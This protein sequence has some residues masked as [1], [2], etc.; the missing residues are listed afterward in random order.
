MRFCRSRSCGCPQSI[1]AERRHPRGWLSVW[2]SILERPFAAPGRV[3]RRLQSPPA[4]GTCTGG[5]VAAKRAIELGDV[6]RIHPHV[7]K[8]APA[9]RRRHLGRRPDAGATQDLP[10][11]IRSLR[12][13]N[14]EGALTLRGPSLYHDPLPPKRVRTKRLA[15]H[16]DFRRG[17]V[18]VCAKYQAE[19]PR[20]RA[21][22]HLSV[23]H[24]QL[25]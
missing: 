17:D 18:P 7:S 5:D 2:L 8:S 12:R 23:V 14:G 20:T 25:H 10:K 22:L 9:T 13:S 11:F 15:R 4:G 3:S 24:S 1:A 16:G 21:D 6:D 19:N